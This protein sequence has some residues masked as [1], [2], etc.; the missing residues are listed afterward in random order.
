MRRPAQVALG[1]ALILGG[2]LIAL[3]FTALLFI[4]DCAAGC[5]TNGERAPAFGI[6]GVGAGALICGALLVADR[7]RLAWGA[8]FAAAGLIA[9]VGGL[10]SRGTMGW[11]TAAAGFLVAALAVW[12][13]RAK[14]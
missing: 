10:V 1:I 2:L 8:G 12:A 9:F 11:I 6:I 4:A 7:A 3:F 5:Q 13:L 14:T